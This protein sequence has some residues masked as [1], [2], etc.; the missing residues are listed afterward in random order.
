MVFFICG[1]VVGGTTVTVAVDAI[2]GA[3]LVSV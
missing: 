1:V 2:A 3:H